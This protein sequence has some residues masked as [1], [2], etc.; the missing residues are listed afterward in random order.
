MIYIDFRSSFHW[1]REGVNRSAAQVYL[2]GRAAIRG[3]VTVR[4]KLPIKDK[5]TYKDS[6]TIRAKAKATSKG[7]VM[8]RVRPV[9]RTKDKVMPYCRLRCRQGSIG[10]NV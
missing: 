1:S 10:Y 5:G 8:A 6:Q 2:M 4:A 3:K 9:R 7:K